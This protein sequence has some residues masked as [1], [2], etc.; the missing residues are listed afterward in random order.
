MRSPHVPTREETLL[1]ANRGKPAQ[2][3]RPITAEIKKK[4]KKMVRRQETQY[5][6]NLKIKQ[7]V[8]E[9]KLSNNYQQLWNNGGT[10]I[11]CV[12]ITDWAGSD[13]SDH[14]AG[15]FLDGPCL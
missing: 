12:F 10:N 3:W 7:N 11:F 9:I 8:S 15:L 6:G 1:A 14:V 13:F 4:K 5:V 2:Q